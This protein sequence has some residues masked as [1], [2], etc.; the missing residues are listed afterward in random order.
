MMNR[1]V[2]R[3]KNLVLKTFASIE[4]PATN[5]PRQLLILLLLQQLGQSH[6]GRW[7]DLSSRQLHSFH[8]SWGVTSD[9]PRWAASSQEAAAG[10][11]NGEGATERRV[12]SESSRP[13]QAARRPPLAERTA[14]EREDSGSEF[15][16]KFLSTTSDVILLLPW[17]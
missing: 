15:P 6:E 5:E 16:L 8:Q 7:V 10:E 2:E 11:A 14:R 13:R 1:G 3:S 17:L 12:A 9:G 4:I